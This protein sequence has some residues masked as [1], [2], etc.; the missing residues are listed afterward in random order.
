VDEHTAI[1]EA[2]RQRNPAAARAA[3]RTH[4]SAVLDALLFATEEKAL[5]A[6]RQATEAKRARY[7]RATA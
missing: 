2:L 4:L 7:T 6:A 3:M 1:L 5:E